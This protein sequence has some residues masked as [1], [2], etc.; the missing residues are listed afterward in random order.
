M[1]L[2]I[3]IYKV[4]FAILFLS[5]MF[6]GSIR[7]PIGPIRLDMIFSI[8]ILL[9]ILV[10]KKSISKNIIIKLLPFT[11]FILYFIIYIFLLVILFS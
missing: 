11:F 8:V 6:I 5:S 2:S 3:N 10:T 9:F 4:F 7:L 1:T